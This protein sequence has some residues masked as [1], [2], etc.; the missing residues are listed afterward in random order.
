MSI[1]LSEA[2][3]ALN[4][5]HTK[6]PIKRSK[7]GDA[8]VYDANTGHN[9]IYSIVHGKNKSFEE[10]QMAQNK[11]KDLITNLNEYIKLN[12]NDELVDPSNTNHVLT[13]SNLSSYMTS[14]TDAFTTATKPQSKSQWGGRRKTR[15]QR[16]TKVSRKS[17]KASRSCKNLRR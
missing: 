12:P 6:L 17:K 13:P 2:Q 9:Y 10:K 15:R 5:L 14:V 3:E 11:L 4:E 16:K 8:M 1:T 7:Y